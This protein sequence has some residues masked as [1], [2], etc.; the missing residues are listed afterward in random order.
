MKEQFN[1]DGLENGAIPGICSQILS[2]RKSDRQLPR[3][4]AGRV[5]TLPN[6]HIGSFR[7]VPVKIYSLGRL[8]LLLNDKPAEFGRKAPRKPLE[9]LKAIIA[10]GGRDVSTVSLASA[11]WPDVEGD[12]AQ[13]SLDITLHRLRKIL[14]DERALVLKDGKVSLDAAVCWVDVWE[15]ERSLG[16]L[17]RLGRADHTGRQ[18]LVLQQLVDR[19]LGLY[20]DHFLGT[21]EVNSWSVSLRE[22]MRSKFIHALLDIGRYWEKHGFW[23]KAIQCYQK[24]IAVDD[25]IEVF[26]Q[27]LMACCLETGRFSEGMSSYRQCRQIL[28]VVLGLRPEP[29]TEVLYM[30]LKNSRNSRHMA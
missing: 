7:V 30:R 27:R 10:L 25:L 9:L 17:Q 29:E 19:V 23:D 5:V 24:G 13:R 12:A 14:A 8:S 2:R 3:G 11:L 22:R 16:M 6:S 18:A 20:Q 1:L 26:Y 4:H 28:S 21:D 15:F